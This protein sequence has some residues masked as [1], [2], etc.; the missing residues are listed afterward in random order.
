M[1][2][3]FSSVDGFAVALP[4]IRDNDTASNAST[5]SA[6]SSSRGGVHPSG[7]PGHGHPGHPGYPRNHQPRPQMI[8]GANDFG[9]LFNPV[10]S[11]SSSS[12]AV[13]PQQQQ[14]PPSL[15]MMGYDLSATNTPRP[16]LPATS[17]NAPP[18]PPRGVSVSPSRGG[19]IRHSTAAR[20]L[21]QN[22]G[23]SFQGAGAVWGED[24]VEAARMNAASGEGS[25]MEGVE[26]NDVFP[27]PIEGVM[28]LNDAEDNAQED[29][30]REDE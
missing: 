14:Q 29:L 12:T 28:P 9:F 20:S 10:A 21:S 11:S 18:L 22:S 5:H 1:F 17:G 8:G 13:V 2:P 30:P 25:G 19:V 23:G 4:P 15:Q 27:E 6:A 7:T 3:S 16:F 24:D 26:V